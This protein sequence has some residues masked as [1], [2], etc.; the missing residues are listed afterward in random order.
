ML[1][2]TQQKRVKNATKFQQM[3]GSFGTCKCTYC[4][5][6]I[7]HKSEEIILK[8]M[9]LHLR[10]AH[11]E[12]ATRGKKRTTYHRKADKKYYY[13]GTMDK[14]V[15]ERAYHMESETIKN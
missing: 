15:M 3:A 1:S 13:G 11:G 2:K 9:K 12:E 5:F 4:G 7:Q 10:V 6:T 8:R 14:R